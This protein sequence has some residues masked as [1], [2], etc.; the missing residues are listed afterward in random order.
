MRDIAALTL[1]GST[2]LYKTT[3]PAETVSS[4]L[5]YIIFK[6]FCQEMKNSLAVCYKFK[7][8]GNKK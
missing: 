2:E 3:V 5:Y 7:L 4:D 6:N 8:N 1:H